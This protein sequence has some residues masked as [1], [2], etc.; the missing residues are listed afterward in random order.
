MILKMGLM[1]LV[2]YLYP[3]A[4]SRGYLQIVFKY[5]KGILLL[6]ACGNS[7]AGGARSFVQE[8]LE[9]NITGTNLKH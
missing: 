4:N 1:L 2:S 3:Q 5:A 9:R 8:I 7:L 6:S